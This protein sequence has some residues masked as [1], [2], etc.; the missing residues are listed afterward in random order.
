MR[1]PLENIYADHHASRRGA[2]FV[3][4]G[5]ERGA[6]L[7]TNIGAGKKVLDI[8]CRDG[9]LTKLYREG[10]D[11]TGLDIDSDAL[12]RAHK[13]GIET[14]QVDLNGEWGVPQRD[15]DVVVAAEVIEHL[16]YP[17]S[18]IAKAAAALKDDGILLGTVP[19]AFSLKNRLRLLFLKK[20]RTPL[21]DPTHI[22]HFTVQELE[23]VLQKHFAQV[24]IV[25]A[26]AAGPLARYAPQWFAFDLMFVATTPRRA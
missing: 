21:A 4:L 5:D 25:G 7:R 1:E 18:V 12:G 14:R 9:A 16:Y 24:Q 3:L 26:G 13:L 19:N 6:F 20:Q 2:G 15:F 23:S 8:G 10:N 17:D 22:N 11:V